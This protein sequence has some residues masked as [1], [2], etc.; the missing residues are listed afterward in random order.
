VKLELS[1]VDLEQQKK[2]VEENNSI[3]PLEKSYKTDQMLLK[4]L[5]VDVGIAIMTWRR[6]RAMGGERWMMVVTCL[7]TCQQLGADQ[8]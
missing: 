8:S 5:P 3:E 4:S 1:A 6:W 2:I 7:I